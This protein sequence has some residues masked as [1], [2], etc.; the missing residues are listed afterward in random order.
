MR[1][2]KLFQKSDLMQHPREHYKNLEKLE[3]SDSNEISLKNS[4]EV[5]K[6]LF[7]LF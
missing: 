1:D 6:M 7:T 2:C 4:L 3:E 5:I